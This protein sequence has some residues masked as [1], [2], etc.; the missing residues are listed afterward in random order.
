MTAISDDL[1]ERAR[2]TRIED[3][4]ERRGIKLVGRVDRC[5]PALDARVRSIFD[6][7]R[8][9]L[10]QLSRLRRY[11]DVIA[12]VM[13]VDGVDFRTAGRDALRRAR[14]R[15]QTAP[16]RRRVRFPAG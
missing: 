9:Q 15:E 14:G 7:L 2:A 1:I 13:H 6:D 12:L 10:L 4:I 3:E 5:A 16:A 11:G 8:K